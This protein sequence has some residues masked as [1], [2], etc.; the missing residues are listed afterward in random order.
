MESRFLFY[1]R[2]F[3]ILP[4]SIIGAIL[5]QGIVVLISYINGIPDWST[6]LIGS[7]I[8]GMLFV[9]SGLYMSPKKTPLIANILLLLFSI[10]SVGIFI[11][12]VTGDFE[13]NIWLLLLNL[14]VGILGAFYATNIV[15]D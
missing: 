6:H 4:A 11:I 7:T 5:G 2:F 13:Y 3:L 8:I 15:R 12:S 14:I 1:L 10:I 9:F